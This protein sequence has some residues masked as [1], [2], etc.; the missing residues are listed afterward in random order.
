MV[1]DINRPAITAP[2]AVLFMGAGIDPAAFQ[3]AAIFMGLFDRVVSPWAHFVPSPAQRM[4]LFVEGNIIWCVFGRFCPPIDINESIDVPML[5]QF[6]SRD[7]V[8]GGVQADVFGG[9][10]KGMTSEIIHGIQEVQAVMAADL[11]KLKH[12]REFHF[13]LAISVRKHI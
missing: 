13:F 7:I 1:F 9:K 5:Q 2:G 8:M 12:E 6:I 10:A 4:P 11:R 3:R